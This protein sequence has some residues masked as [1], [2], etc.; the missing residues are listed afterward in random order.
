MDSNIPTQSAARVASR[1]AGPATAVG[2]STR[3]R[4]L[5]EALRLFVDQGYRATS[6]AQIAEAS[7]LSPGAGGLYRHFAR[8]EDVLAAVLEQEIA[9]LDELGSV[10]RLLPLGDLRAEITL[11][12]RWALDEIGRKTNLIRV[13]QRNGGEVPS[14][15]GLARERWIRR[16]YDDATRVIDDIFRRAD[17]VPHDSQALAAVILGAIANYRF[18]AAVFGEPP[19][20]VSEDRFVGAIV[21][22][23]AASVTTSQAD[24]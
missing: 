18:E 17:S 22:L 6:V 10:E 15:V 20:D 3:E 19:R 21:D 11:L 12:A 9:G 8:K 2:G 7:G 16:S 23:V 14:L 4:I 1:L 13:I 24:A 5:R